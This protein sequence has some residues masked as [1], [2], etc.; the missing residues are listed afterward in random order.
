MTEKSKY[1][2]I[3]TGILGIIAVVASYCLS[4]GDYEKYEIAE[5]EKDS[6]KIYRPLVTIEPEPSEEPAPIPIYY[7]LKNEENKLNLYEIDGEAK[8]VIK[9]TEFSPEMFPLEDRVLLKEG[10]KALS[11]EEGIE[12]LE[13]F[14]S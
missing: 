9:S 2:F 1:L 4:V 8:K 10:I 11:L 6:V 3:G 13:N 12:I 14:I 7:I 5:A